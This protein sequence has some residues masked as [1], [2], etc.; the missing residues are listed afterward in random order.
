MEAPGC[1]YVA[2]RKISAAERR[3]ILAM[4]GVSESIFQ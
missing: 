2:S 1:D 3:E 4:L